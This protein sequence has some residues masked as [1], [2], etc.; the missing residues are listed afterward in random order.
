LSNAL[1]NGLRGY[2]ENM[3]GF[4]SDIQQQNNVPEYFLARQ[5]Y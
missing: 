3:I 4:Y 5:S 2:P 1:S